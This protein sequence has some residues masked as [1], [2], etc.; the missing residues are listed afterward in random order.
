MN[1][2]VTNFYVDRLTVRCHW[3]FLSGILI[4]V[5]ELIPGWEID[6]LE[7]IINQTLGHCRNLVNVLMIKSILIVFSG[8]KAYVYILYVESGRSTLMIPPFSVKILATT[9]V[10]H[11]FN[12]TCV[13][14]HVDDTL[15]EYL[16]NPPHV[17]QLVLKIPQYFLIV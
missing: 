5:L 13:T 12:Y 8:F 2:L 7:K 3:R 16:V 11:D 1:K 6:L 9:L 10:N 4:S 15:C 17:S 14:H